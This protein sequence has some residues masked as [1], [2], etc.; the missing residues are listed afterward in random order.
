MTNKSSKNSHKQSNPR[1]KKSSLKI[2]FNNKCLQIEKIK[3]YILKLG[4]KVVNF[5]LNKKLHQIGKQLK[6]QKLA[7]IILQLKMNKIRLKHL[8]VR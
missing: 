1:L 3:I 6:L 4:K 2:K 7:I 5:I 8:I